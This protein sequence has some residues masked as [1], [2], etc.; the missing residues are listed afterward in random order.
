MPAQMKLTVLGSG[1]CVPDGLR[2]SAGY[3]I[4]TAE[5]RVM[6]DCG[7]GTL[8]ALARYGVP[9]EQLTHLVVS[10]FH[11]DHIGELA[12]LMFAFCHGMQTKR[13][14]PLKLIGPRGLERV[15]AG[16]EAAFGKKLFQPAFP[17]E[18]DLIEE[19]GRRALGPETTLSVSKT[20]H[21]R[22][23]LALRI[24]NG[25]RSVCYTGD[26]GYDGGLASFFARADI[27]ISE[28]SYAERRPGVLHLSIEDAGRMAAQAEVKQLVLT[29][30][31]FKTGEVD[32]KEEVRR[33]FQGEV[34]IASDGLSFEL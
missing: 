9:W 26:T 10:H 7:A 29:H 5:A 28:C 8:H 21:N 27:L 2:N 20:P 1:T 14:L 23:S 19:D 6:L 22:E 15:V 11:V 16:L 18:I 17:V 32:V 33:H 25:G 24:D 31:Y 30:F 12:A 34:V 4:E 13:E 3:F